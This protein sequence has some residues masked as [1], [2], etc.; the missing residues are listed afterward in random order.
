MPAP[1]D[2]I[3]ELGVGVF[4]DLCGSIPH[5]GLAIHGRALV[6]RH[7]DAPRGHGP[8]VVQVAQVHPV[9]VDEHVDG[10]PTVLGRPG[11]GEPADGACRGALVV[12]GA[13]SLQML[14]TH[15]VVRPHFVRVVHRVDPIGV[16]VWGVVDAKRGLAPGFGALVAVGVRAQVLDGVDGLEKARGRDQLHRGGGGVI[17]WEPKGQTEVRRVVEIVVWR[18]QNAQVFRC[19]PLPKELRAQ[20]VELHGARAHFGLGRSGPVLAF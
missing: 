1:I 20:V 18:R 6:V 14:H 16:D 9:H 19:V 13:V 11:F 7:I 10:H 5:L 15:N 17:A 2:G 4:L 8:L 12:G 3:E